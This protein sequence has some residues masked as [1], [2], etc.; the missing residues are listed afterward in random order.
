M[1]YSNAS[2][3]GEEKSSRIQKITPF[4]WFDNQAEQA[5]NYY[6]SVFKNSKMGRVTRYGKEGYEIHGMDEG[7]VMTVDFDIENQKFIALNGGPVFKFNEAISFQVLC[8]SQKELDYYWEKLS[9]GGD[10]NAQQCGW[11]KDKYGVSWQIVPRV[12]YNL[13]LD[14]DQLKSQ[15]VMKAMLQMKKLDIQTLI[16]AY[17]KT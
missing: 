12:L 10:K 8:D 6:V 16:Q 4:L 13:I 17:E 11:L 15:R 1:N 14:K 3:I 2:K 7:S 5:A 9:E